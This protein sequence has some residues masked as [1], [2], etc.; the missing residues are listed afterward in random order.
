[1]VISPY[2]RN[3]ITLLFKHHVTDK[4]SCV[5]HL[6]LAAV[7]NKIENK[8]NVNCLSVHWKERD[9]SVQF[10]YSLHTEHLLL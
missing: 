2:A 10:K 3:P 5:S 4:C 9:I 8:I 1:M 6:Y 7:K